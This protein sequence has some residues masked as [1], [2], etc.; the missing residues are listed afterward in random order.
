MY[1][2]QY[3]YYTC[4][5]WKRSPQLATEIPLERNTCYATTEMVVNRNI[6]YATIAPSTTS[7]AQTNDTVG[8]T[9]AATELYENPF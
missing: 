5:H 3:D 8:Q 6:S 9:S 4:M 7:G 2:H 1:F